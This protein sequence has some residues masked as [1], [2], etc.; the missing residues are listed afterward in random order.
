MSRFKGLA[1]AV[2]KEEIKDIVVSTNDSINESNLKSETS[3]ESIKNETPV[4]NQSNDP[5]SSDS[6]QNSNEIENSSLQVKNSL[7]VQENSNQHK[8]QKK[9]KENYQEQIEH[10]M[11]NNKHLENESTR[12]IAIPSSVYEMLANIKDDERR[13]GRKVN[14]N[15][16]VMMFL[17]TSMDNK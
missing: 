14:I 16:L 7:E 15:A 13:A 11:Q 5:L 2:K 8:K 4:F 1:N 9:S 12:N 17:K 6:V 10:F 3:I